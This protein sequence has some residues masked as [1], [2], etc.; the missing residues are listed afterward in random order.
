MSRVEDA[1]ADAL[2]SLGD[3]RIVP[4]A[5]KRFD[6]AQ[7]NEQKRR[8]AMICLGLGGDAPMRRL[9]S[10]FKLGLIKLPPIDPDQKILDQATGRDL[11]G[12]IKYFD[13]AQTP[14]CNEALDALSNVDHPLHGTAIAC[15]QA[16]IESSDSSTDTWFYHP[17]YVKLMR[18]LLDRTESIHRTYKL[19]ENGHGGWRTKEAG[20]SDESDVLADP[21]QCNT[22]ADCR[23]CDLMGRRL[24]EAI[25]GRKPPYHPLSSR[26]VTNGLRNCAHSSITMA[27][28]CD[29]TTG[30]EYQ[31]AYSRVYYG[32]KLIPHFQSRGEP[33]S[34]T[35]VDAGRAIFSLGPKAKVEP[36][37]LPLFA[38]WKNDPA[39]DKGPLLM[40]VQAERDA[41]GKLHY[42]IVSH[43]EIRE[44]SEGDLRDIR[45]V[46][47]P[48][49]P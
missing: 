30:E 12:F 26:I 42:G 28:T 9:A 43:H 7:A 34:A 17:Y 25:V 10:E 11:A 29:K 2:I 31:L 41:D 8:W 39:G 5:A 13:D 48:K 1:Y 3:T 18:P 44:A 36:L 21:K 47:A 6:A 4:E 24:S 46:E 37:Q 35:D 23:L 38:R 16:S 20:G 27:R 22:S 15:L 45:P 33:A 40:I 19:H 14:Y 32:P 49:R